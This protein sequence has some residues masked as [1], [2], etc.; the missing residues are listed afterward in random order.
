MPS[1]VLRQTC[2]VAWRYVRRWACPGIFTNDGG[3]FRLLFIA[4]GEDKDLLPYRSN[5]LYAESSVTKLAWRLSDQRI[6]GDEFESDS[7]ALWEQFQTLCDAIRDGR[8]SGMSRRMG[9]T[10]FSADRDFSGAGRI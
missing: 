7:T 3:A 5:G 10:L 8:Q 4:Y 6:N 2:S 1:R 9:G